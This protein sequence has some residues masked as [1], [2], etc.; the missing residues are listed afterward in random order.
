MKRH[1]F[2]SQPKPWAKSIGWVPAPEILTLLRLIMSVIADGLE[3]DQSDRTPGR[4]EP[5][6]LSNCR[7]SSA[8]SV[9]NDRANQCRDGG[10][11]MPRTDGPLQ[12]RPDAGG[13]ALNRLRY[14]GSSRSGSKSS[15][16]CTHI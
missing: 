9:Q 3:G 6:L 8:A 4:P 15:S 16:R 1:M 10:P 7:A 14:S 5:S 13:M 12:S 2:W 11:V